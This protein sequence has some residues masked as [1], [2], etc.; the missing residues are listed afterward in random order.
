MQMS[1]SEFMDLPTKDSINKL[2]V[3]DYYKEEIITH[4]DKY[5][6]VCQQIT[7]IRHGYGDNSFTTHIY[8]IQIV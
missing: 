7:N 6:W 8:D 5:H 2:D 4:D 3:N 1:L